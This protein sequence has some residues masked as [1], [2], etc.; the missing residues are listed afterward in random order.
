MIEGAITA[1]TDY[2]RY[3]WWVIYNLNLKVAYTLELDEDSGYYFFTA[4]DIGN[5]INLSLENLL[6]QHKPDPRDISLIKSLS[7]FEYTRLF[8]YLKSKRVYDDKIDWI[9][10]CMDLNSRENSEKY[11]PY[12]KDIAIYKL[13]NGLVFNPFYTFKCPDEQA[14]YTL[15]ELEQRTEDDL[16]DEMFQGALLSWLTTFFQENPSVD[17]SPKYAHEQQV[18]KYLE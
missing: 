13:I 3:A 11:G 10:Y 15:Q 5:H 1:Q 12:N 4:S 17:L 7:D 9:N 14:V 8:L 16:H 2:S 6:T 18:V